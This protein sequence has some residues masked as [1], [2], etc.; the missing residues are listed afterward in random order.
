MIKVTVHLK[1]GSD[2]RYDEVEITKEEIQQLACN[3]AKDRY[4]DG[5]WTTIMAEDEVKIEANF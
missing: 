5:Y 1:S 4:M 3:K 2:S